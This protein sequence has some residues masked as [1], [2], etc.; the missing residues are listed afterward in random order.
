MQALLDSEIKEEPERDTAAGVVGAFKKAAG[1]RTSTIA[2]KFANR[3]STRGSTASSPTK[4]GGKSHR[5]S[6]SQAN[7][8]AA[9]TTT[10]PPHVLE[11]RRAARR[12]ER[13]GR[14][15]TRPT[16]RTVGR[17]CGVGAPVWPR[18]DSGVAAASDRLDPCG[19]GA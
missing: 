5:R 17:L 10:K 18:C 4:S 3:M 8:G 1:S 9:K 7:K 19:G 6:S 11:V 2:N 16:E 13:G 15:H 12:F 14:L